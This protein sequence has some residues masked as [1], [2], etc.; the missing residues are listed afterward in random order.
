MVFS[1]GLRIGRVPVRASMCA[2]YRT[3]AVRPVWKSALVIFLASGRWFDSVDNSMNSRNK[4]TGEVLLRATL[5]RPDSNRFTTRNASIPDAG[6]VW[7]RTKNS[8]SG[9]SIR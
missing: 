1:L 7:A 8:Q 5:E 3:A 4:M 6:R 2:N 9:R